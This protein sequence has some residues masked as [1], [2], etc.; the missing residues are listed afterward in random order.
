MF[1][2]VR[3]NEPSIKFRYLQIRTDKNMTDLLYILYPEYSSTFEEYEKIIY[4]ITSDI[5]ESYVSRFIR[6][7][8][9]IVP[10]EEYNIVR[11]CHSWHLDNKLENRISFEIV[12]HF[13][14]M[15]SSS[16]INHMIRRFN[17]KNK[18]KKNESEVVINKFLKSQ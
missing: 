1:F 2:K 13:L 11:K 9:V 3:G 7:Q 14:N 4:F 15:S 6:K 10:K 12:S 5:Y 18:N 16:A 17:I 8:Y